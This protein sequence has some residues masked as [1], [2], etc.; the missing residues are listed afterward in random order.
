[1]TDKLEELAPNG[2]YFGSHWGDAADFGYWPVE[3]TEESE[4]ITAYFENLFKFGGVEKPT[5]S[6]MQLIQRVY[7]T[8]EEQELICVT[9][10]GSALTLPENWL[11]QEDHLIFQLY[12]AV[13]KEIEPE[14]VRKPVE[15]P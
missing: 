5:D 10:A 11:L 14:R 7:L 1:M 13:P 15:L 2:Y 4:A 9:N 8:F 6:D 3:S 12:E